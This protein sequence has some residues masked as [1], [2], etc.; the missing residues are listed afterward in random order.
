MEEQA[1]T[2][3]RLESGTAEQP[4]TLETAKLEALRLLQMGGMSFAYLSTISQ[5]AAAEL[6]L[7]AKTVPKLVGVGLFLVPIVYFAWLG[8]SALL[9]WSVYLLLEQSLYGLATFFLLQCL[10][11]LVGYAYIRRASRSIGFKQ[12]KAQISALIE[13]IKHEFQ[14]EHPDSQ[15]PSR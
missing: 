12:S 7:S 3:E 14:S 1:T 13:T 5:L 6:V 9:G 10:L 2:T 11:L 8:L 15:Q 4:L